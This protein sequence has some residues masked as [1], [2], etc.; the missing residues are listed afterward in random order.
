MIS[1][2]RLIYSLC[3]AIV[4][5]TPA[6]LPLVLVGVPGAW[7]LVILVVLAGVLA[8]ELAAN[9]LAVE[10]QQP[11][12]LGAAFVVAAWAIKIA[13][14]G[15]LL[16]GWGAAFSALFSLTNARGGLAYL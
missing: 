16:S 10:R 9:W 15:G 11:V 7:G 12:L 2:Q 1:W 13:V 3:L 14:G 6:A 4:E 5:A 8:D